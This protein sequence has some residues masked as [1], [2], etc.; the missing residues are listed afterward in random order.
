MF[1]IILIIVCVILYFWVKNKVFSHKE[2]KR[3][4][5]HNKLRAAEKDIHREYQNKK[6]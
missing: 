1:I 4:N 2:E 3:I 6:R 5:N